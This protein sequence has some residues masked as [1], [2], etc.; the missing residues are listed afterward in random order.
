MTVTILWSH[1]IELAYVF[2]NPQ[3]EIYTGGLYNAELAGTVQDMW[4]NYAR[5]GD[6]S[7][8]EYT[9]EPYTADSRQTMV[10]GGEIGMTKDLK[11]E[12]LS[13]L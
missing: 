10:P 6:P 7:T 1:A 2:R 11:I 12:G 8:E 9:W 5:C 13:E 4:V 3:E